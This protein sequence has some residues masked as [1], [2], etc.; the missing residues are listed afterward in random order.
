M[1]MTTTMTMT[2]KQVK[3]AIEQKAFETI[4]KANDILIGLNR[5]IID[6]VSIVFSNR[7]AKTAGKALTHYAKVGTKTVLVCVL[8]YNL[9]IAM[10]N[11]EDFIKDTVVHEVGHLLSTRLGGKHHDHIWKSCCRKLGIVP[12][13][14]HNMNVAGYQNYACKCGAPHPLTD[15]MAKKVDANPTMYHCRKCKSQLTRMVNVES[16]AKA[17]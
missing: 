1:T 5:P 15:R 6:N 11:F 10:L 17:S 13:R 2:E 12:T 4:V 9:P 3:T 16:L 14:C 7:R 8:T